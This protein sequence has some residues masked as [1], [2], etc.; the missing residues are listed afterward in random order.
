MRKLTFLLGIILS[1]NLYGQ[2]FHA[3]VNAVYNFVPHKMSG[4]EQNALFPKLD[5]FFELVTKNKD[6]YL[7]SLRNELK[8]TDN[9]SYFYFDGGVLL[10]ECSNSEPDL[11][12]IADVLTR[13]DL[14]DVPHDIYLGQL[15]K[16]SIKGANV[17]DAALHILDEPTFQVYI[18]Q[19]A[20][21]LCYG[22]ALKFI[23]P[24]YKSELYIK[25]L[26]SKFGMVSSYKNKMT[27]LDLFIYANCCEADQFLVSIK[28]DTNQPQQI[29]DEVDKTIK[30]TTVS[31][32]QNDKEYSSFFD[33]RK[34][35]LNRISDEAIDELNNFT[36]GMRKSY[37]CN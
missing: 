31:G 7:E 12:L 17:I 26:I 6:K 24:R 8:R 15:L 1:I 19:H 37:K 5:K 11:Q 23:L 36:L 2:D 14:R 9:N 25:Q 13:V 22:E 3:E 16:L 27:C 18:P 4:A 21:T 20:L 34:E 28:S 33:K 32:S 30:L 10:M 29:R 35:A